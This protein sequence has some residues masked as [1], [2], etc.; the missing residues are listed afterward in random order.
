MLPVSACSEHSGVNCAQ[1][2]PASYRPLPDLSPTTIVRFITR[3]CRHGQRVH[4][5]GRLIVARIH[6]VGFTFG[7]LLDLVVATRW[8][9]AR[10]A[11]I[12]VGR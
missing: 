11:G 7:R 4:F 9:Q 3:R 1:A 12:E 6:E 10:H 5:A 2:R 8:E